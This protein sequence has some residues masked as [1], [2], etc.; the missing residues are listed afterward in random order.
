[1]YATVFASRNNETQCA[2]LIFLSSGFITCDPFF[3]LGKLLTEEMLLVISIL[4]KGWSR[5]KNFDPY[6]RFLLL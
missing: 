6:I 4:F 2:P 3:I 1:M 5:T